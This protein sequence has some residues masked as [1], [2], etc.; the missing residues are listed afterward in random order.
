MTTDNLLT[1]LVHHSRHHS[2]SLMV[3][4]VQLVNEVY[5]VQV[6][7]LEDDVCQAA[8][9]PPVDVLHLRNKAVAHLV[10]AAH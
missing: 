5:P 7:C 4:V 3:E 6:V 10:D 2:P 9:V 8:E 1:N